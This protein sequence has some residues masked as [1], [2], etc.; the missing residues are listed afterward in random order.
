[1]ARSTF[2]EASRR[3]ADGFILLLA[4]VPPHASGGLG[5]PGARQATVFSPSLSYRS[6]RCFCSSSPE[7]AE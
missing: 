7:L 5:A 3:E 2:L 1:M 6:F 4:K